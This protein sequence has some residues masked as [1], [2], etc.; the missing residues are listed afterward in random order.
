MDPANGID[1][2]KGFGAVY[3]MMVGGAVIICEAALFGIVYY[4][5]TRRK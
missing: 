2:F 1:I 4:L 5:F 3:I